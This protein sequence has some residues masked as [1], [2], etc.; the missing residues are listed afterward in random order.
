MR[1][2]ALPLALLLFGLSGLGCAAYQYV[3]VVS[4]PPG[5]EIYL[6]GERVGTTPQQLRVNRRD[7]HKV[8]L[9]KAGYQSELFVLELQSGR[10]GVD[11]LVPPDIGVRLRAGADAPSTDREVEIDVDSAERR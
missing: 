8:F 1:A 6:D 3:D 4:N 9:K 7:H 10:D 11:F 5:A 2:R